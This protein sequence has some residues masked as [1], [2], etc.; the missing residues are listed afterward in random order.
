LQVGDGDRRQAA[1]FGHLRNPLNSELL[2]NPRL[3]A[4]WSEASRVQV[5]KARANLVDDTGAED[6]RISRHHLRGFC[7]LNSLLEGSAISYAFKRSRNELW[8]VRITEPGKDLISLIR[9]EV[10]ACIEFIR[11]LV[12]SRANLVIA[13]PCIRQ[14]KEIQQ[15]HGIR[16]DASRRKNV[17]VRAGCECK[18]CCPGPAYA[19]EGIANI[20]VFPGLVLQS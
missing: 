11:V 3:V 14:G 13:D 7:G 10:D 15:F 2:R 16:I 9:V 19:A 8:V 17:E 5:S 18:A 6:V 12:Q 1:V 20:A 4:Y